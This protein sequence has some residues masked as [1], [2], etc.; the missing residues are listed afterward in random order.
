MTAKFKAK[1][2]IFCKKAKFSICYKKAKFN[3]IAVLKPLENSLKPAVE[4]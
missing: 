1:F 4:I 2:S 3:K